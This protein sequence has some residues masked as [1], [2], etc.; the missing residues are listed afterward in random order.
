MNSVICI[1]VPKHD[2]LVFQ[3]STILHELGHVIGLYHEHVRADRDE[4]ID[5][6]MENL[7]P[8]QRKSLKKLNPADVNTYGI[9][10]DVM[11]V[12]HYSSMVRHLHD[13]IMKAQGVARSRRCR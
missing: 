7:N 3:K 8:K 11:S 2:F 1:S 12:M 10:Y 5:I 13:Q 4:Y 9:P 6:R